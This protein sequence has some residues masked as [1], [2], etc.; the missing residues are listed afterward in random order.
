RP[1]RRAGP[2]RGA[3]R[4]AGRRVPPARRGR[5]R[6]AGGRRMTARAPAR[7]ADAAGRAATADSG[8]DPSV[9]RTLGRAL[10]FLAPLRAR[11]AGKLALVLLSVVPLVLVAWP[12]KMVID[13]VIEG[14]PVVPDAYP[15]FVR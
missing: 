1:P 8:A 4:A 3:A 7:G 13:H 6:R 5:E 15:W 9:V 12:G 14:R 2:P 11:V 10:R